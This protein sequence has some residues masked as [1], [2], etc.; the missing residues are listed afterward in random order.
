MENYLNQVLDNRYEIVEVIGTGGMAVVYKAHDRKLNRLVAV[1]ML[2]EELRSD[3][4]LRTRFH[5]ESEAMARLN[6]NNIIKVFDVSSTPES[7]YFVMEIVDGITLKQYINQRGTLS[8]KEALHFTVQILKA[9]EHAHLKKIVHRD[10]KPQNIMILRDGTVKVMDFGIARVMEKQ[11]VTQTKSTAFGTV[12][13]I[14]PEQARGDAIDGRADI[15]S[16]GVML[17]EMLTGSL[18][19][20]GDS[21]L[22]VA[23]QHINS[24]PE[25]PSTLNPEIPES[26]EI[27]TL[28]AMCGDLELRY[29]TA[30]EM[31]D[32]I[33]GFRKDPETFVPSGEYIHGENGDTI[34]FR[35]Y[36]DTGAVPVKPQTGK[37]PREPRTRT[38]FLPLIAVLIALM[39]VAAGALTL[40]I[41][42]LSPEAGA[43]DVPVPY[44]IGRTYADLLEDS[45]IR[46]ELVVKEEVYNARYDKG[47]VIDQDKASG[48]TAKAGSTIELT[49][50]LGPHTIT[51]PNYF[52]HLY[53]EAN[54]ELKSLMDKTVNIQFQFINSSS[55]TRNY[56]VSTDPVAGDTV[57][58]GQTVTFF[59]SAGSEVE[60]VSVPRLVGETL[61]H[62][63]ELIYA[64]GLSVGVIE[65]GYDPDAEPG[66]VIAQSSPESYLV[67]KGTAIN[68][69]VA[70]AETTAAT[71]ATSGGP[72]SPG[73]W[74]YDPALTSS[75]L[76]T[77]ELP[78]EGRYPDR[79]LFE[80]RAD[81]VPVYSETREKGDDAVTL[82]ISGYGSILIEVYIDSVLW[83]SERLQV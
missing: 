71:A 55:V 2:K 50:S 8:I 53:T 9:L 68:L 3:E 27:I 21:P 26:L 12:H 82:E 83:K 47:V 25:K 70:S 18:P 16:V 76:L 31:I 37:P 81:G 80:V 33:E 22:A 30:R 5:A 60:T 23:M 40:W 41:K 45:S 48:S 20:T 36:S 79:F 67:P 24:V 13:Y 64:A 32:E 74:T 78:T 46:F 39:V 10:I 77:V 49:L 69:T 15:Y 7:E 43:E 44:M 6:H 17:Y 59:I 62:A 54:A 1:K 19:Y 11:G 4:E 51:M 73:Q 75:A 61:T 72:I 38:N 58:E 42:L 65:Q 34:K 29:H 35:P 57:V 63:R 52:N 28:K 14:A 56:I 66:R